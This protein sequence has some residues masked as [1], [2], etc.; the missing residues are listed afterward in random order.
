VAAADAGLRW[1]AALG[2]EVAL[3]PRTLRRARQVLAEL[4]RLPD[5][6]DRLT[7][8][9]ERTAAGLEKSVGELSLSVGG[10]MNDRLEHLDAVVSDLRDTLTGLIGAIPGVRRTL[11]SVVRPPR[12]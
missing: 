12:D 9:L 8:T 6:L 1:L 7:D 3:A 2:R 5:Q 10:G 4:A 11:Q